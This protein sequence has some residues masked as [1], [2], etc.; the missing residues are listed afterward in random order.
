[1]DTKYE[2]D[3]EKP[4]NDEQIGDIKFHLDDAKL[5]TSKEHGLT[6]LQGLK[7]YRKAIGWS[8]MLSMAVI[9]EGY[10]TTLVGLLSGDKGNLE[11]CLRPA[12]NRLDR[13][14]VLPRSTILLGTRWSMVCPPSRH[15]GRLQVSILP[16]VRRLFW[17]GL[18]QCTYSYEWSVHRRDSWSPSHWISRRLVRQQESHDWSYNLDDW[19]REA[20]V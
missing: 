15:R 9:M 2:A 20:S 3:P 18:T 5:A 19:I 16:V 7:P 4:A 6:V 11:L 17:V 13:T 14:W 1:M 10:D 8:V 12:P